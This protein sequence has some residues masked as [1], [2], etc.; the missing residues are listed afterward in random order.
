[1]QGQIS[2]EKPARSIR[3]VL[4]DPDNRN[5][6]AASVEADAD[7]YYKIPNLPKRTYTILSYVDGKKLDRRSVRFLCREG[8]TVS[9]DFSYR[10]S[11][12][13]LTLHFPDEDPDV[14]DISEVPRD[15]PPD[16]FREFKK[17]ESDYRIRNDE[18]A[19]QRFESI[20]KVAPD[21]YA[22][23]MRLGLIYQQQGCFEDSASEYL[24]ASTIS[25]RS[26]QP[27]LNLAS[28]QLQAAVV[29]AARDKMVANALETLD[30]ALRIKPDSALAYCLSGAAHA[31]VDS[32]E[33]AELDFK[34]ALELDEQLAAA[35]LMLANLY[36]HHG[37]WKLA[38]ENLNKYLDDFPY[39]PDWLVVRKMLDSATAKESA[40]PSRQ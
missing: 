37:D 16:V 34:R 9:K 38:A 35:R 19:I 2:V 40:R 31:R 6:E 11:T 7:G 39:S 15:Y 21:F 24:L 27:L 8:S 14:A 36:M 12:S 29:P 5:N 4:Q 23:H 25:S 28:V 22:V 20:A 3:V 1:M 13:T 17:A 26:P 18:R 33:S 10:K 32:F 30:R